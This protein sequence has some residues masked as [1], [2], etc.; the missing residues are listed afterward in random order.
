MLDLDHV[1]AE[2]AKD[3]RDQGTGKELGG[4][5]DRN[6]C[7]RGNVARTLNPDNG[8]YSSPSTQATC[9]AHGHV[10]LV[11]WTPEA[12]DDLNG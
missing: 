3:G 5:D 2:V 7:K 11:I 12:T 6:A 4:I 10:E 9:A 1:G 8:R